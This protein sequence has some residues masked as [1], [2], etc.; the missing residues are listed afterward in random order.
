MLVYHKKSFGL[1][2]MLEQRFLYSRSFAAM[3]A[4]GMVSARKMLSAVL[5]LALPPVLL[6]RT[7]SILVRKRRNLREFLLTLPVILLFVMAWAVGEGVGYLGG[8]G[9]SLSR[10]E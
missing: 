10:V 1:G 8:P 5:S 7:G 2:E 6:W 3:R 9:D 4:A